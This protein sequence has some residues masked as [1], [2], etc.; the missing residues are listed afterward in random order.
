MLSLVVC[1]PPAP[2]QASDVPVVLCD[3]TL[4]RFHSVVHQWLQSSV[5][6]RVRRSLQLSFPNPSCIASREFLQS[7][8]ESA[9]PSKMCHIWA[10]LVHTC[11]KPVCMCVYV[12]VHVCACIYVHIKIHRFLVICIIGASSLHEVLPSVR[13]KKSAYWPTQL[14][15][16]ATATTCT[17]FRQLAPSCCYGDTYDEPRARRCATRRNAAQRD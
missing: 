12:S 7:V 11:S 8:S 16:S 10:P 4:I 5:S 2:F 9:S 6:P 14:R 1:I 3:V 17:S 13:R 15:W